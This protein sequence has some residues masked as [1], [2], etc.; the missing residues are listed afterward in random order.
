MHKARNVLI[1][2]NS[3]SIQN[4]RLANTVLAN[5]HGQ[6]FTELKVQLGDAAKILDVQRFQFHHALPKWCA[7]SISQSTQ[8]VNAVFPLTPQ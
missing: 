5:D 7:L 4:G 6:P 2:Q 3:Q 8:S 1:Q